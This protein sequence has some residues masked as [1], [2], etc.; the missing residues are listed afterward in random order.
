[1]LP[2]H[3]RP[4][5]VGDM[6]SY[7]GEVGQVTGTRLAVDTREHV[8]T[9]QFPERNAQSHVACDRL[10]VFGTRRG[11]IQEMGTR[12]QQPMPFLRPAI[13]TVRGRHFDTIIADDITRGDEEADPRVMRAWVEGV[14]DHVNEVEGREEQFG[15]PLEFTRAGVEEWA[16]RQGPEIRVDV[17]ANRDHIDVT[18]HV[19]GFESITRVSMFQLHRAR[20]P[21]FMLRTASEAALQ[22][23]RRM[24]GVLRRTAEQAEEFRTVTQQINFE[25]RLLDAAG[26]ADRLREM[27]SD[28]GLTM[29][30]ATRAMRDFQVQYTAQP[31]VI[32]HLT[33]DD[34]QLRA[35]DPEY[36]DDDF[37]F[38]NEQRW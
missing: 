8:I 6:V 18:A 36:G 30:E 21:F 4:L 11:P 12:S 7:N 16:A 13:E 5:D 25:P 29:N 1:M 26:A 20:D 24:A 37:D 32:T 9:I 27:A 38:D 19:D 3:I 28:V 10:E 31:G 35:V 17:E 15:P 23:V 22:A 2:E 34:G 14:T 33:D